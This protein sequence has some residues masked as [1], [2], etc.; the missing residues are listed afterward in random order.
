L[1]VHPA[2]VVCRRDAILTASQVITA[3]MV[4][5]A[6]IIVT[7]FVLDA[8]SQHASAAPHNR[9]DHATR[10]ATSVTRTYRLS[11]A[12]QFYNVNEAPLR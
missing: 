3:T 7:A 9:T 10:D 4:L 5:L 6:I 8:R 11:D 1:T 12:T 2:P